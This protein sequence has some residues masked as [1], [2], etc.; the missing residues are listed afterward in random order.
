MFQES[1][2][3]QLKEKGISKELVEKQIAEF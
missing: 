3:D 2:L 1:D